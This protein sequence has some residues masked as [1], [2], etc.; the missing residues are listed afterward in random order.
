MVFRGLDLLLKVL[1]RSHSANQAGKIK[2]Q[3]NCRLCGLFGSQFN[4]TK[5][6]RDI[7]VP[8]IE[9]TM[10]SVF[11]EVPSWWRRTC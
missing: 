8:G 3:K 4:G 7:C 11:K 6:E 9:A 10:V 2:S 5:V 1:L